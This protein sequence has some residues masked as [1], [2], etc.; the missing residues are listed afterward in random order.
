MFNHRFK[1]HKPYDLRVFNNSCGFFLMLYTGYRFYCNSI[2][3]YNMTRATYI[4]ELLKMVDKPETELALK[5]M[6]NLTA[7]QEVISEIFK[8]FNT[9]PKIA[10]LDNSEA[11]KKCQFGARWECEYSVDSDNQICDMSNPVIYYN[12]DYPAS[13]HPYLIL[14][15]LINLSNARK[16]ILQNIR[17]EIKNLSEQETVRESDEIEHKV[18]LIAKETL[19][20]AKHE[21]R[22]YDDGIEDYDVLILEQY[23]LRH[24]NSPGFLKH[25]EEKLIC[26]IK[27]CNAIK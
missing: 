1:I 18:G 8:E 9:I 19:K 24:P 6:N 15:E 3:N 26:D 11:L 22:Y 13:L 12:K 27:S 5:K 20:S 7:I 2:E 23:K 14:F 17:Y 25:H 21:G 10:G 16:Y 4:N